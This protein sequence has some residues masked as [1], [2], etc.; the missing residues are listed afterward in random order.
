MCFKNQ[1]S[2]FESRRFGIFIFFALTAYTLTFCFSTVQISIGKGFKQND[3]CDKPGGHY[4]VSLKSWLFIQGVVNCSVVVAFLLIVATYRIVNERKLVM[5]TIGVLSAYGFWLVGW[6]VVGFIQIFKYSSTCNKFDHSLYQFT[7]ASAIVG[8]VIIIIN[9]FII[10]II[11]QFGLDHPD[12]V[13]LGSSDDE[14]AAYNRRAS[15]EDEVASSTHHHHPHRH[16]KGRLA[17]NHVQQKQ[18]QDEKR[19]LLA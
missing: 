9:G 19:P 15:V 18:H 14:E 3:T 16:Q 12:L 7:L 8:V 17:H 2:Q 5:A 11:I 1:G 4:L 13:S 6:V 10:G